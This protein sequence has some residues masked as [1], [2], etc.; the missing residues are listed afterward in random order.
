MLPS[1]YQASRD[2]LL[3]YLIIDEAH[4]ISH[5]GD[6]FRPDFQMLAGVRRGLLS[7]SPLNS[8]FKTIL[9]SATFT[10]DS[11]ETIDALFGPCESVHMCASVHLRP[12]PQYWVHFEDDPLEKDRKIL[13]T[14]RH[15]PRPFILYVTKVSDAKRWIGILRKTGYH[16]VDC[17]HG[18][19]PGS[20]RRRIIDQWSQNELDGI[21]A[22]SAFGVGIDKQ[23]V[24]TVIHASVPETLDR[25]Y[26]EVGRGGR[27]GCPSGSIIIYSQSDVELANHLSSPSLI[28][29]DLAFERWSTMYGKSRQ[30]DKI[31]QLI[32]I[33]LAVVPPRLRRQTEYNESWN[34]R[35]IIMMA[36]AGILDLESQS[37]AP[38]PQIE[39]ELKFDFD[40][41][42]DEYW[43]NY[44]RRTVVRIKEFDHQSPDT[45]ETLI[46]GERRRAIEL[47]TRSRLILD[48]LLGRETE[49]SELLDHLYRSNVPGRSVI[50]S[51]ACGGCPIHR[52]LGTINIH[53]SAPPAFGIERVGHFDLS[54]FVDRFPQ[55]DLNSPILLPFDEPLADSVLMALL[56]DFIGLFGVHEI[57]IQ[58]AFRDRNSDFIGV[59][60]HSIDG[61]VLIQ[62]LE[63]EVLRPSSYEL[64]RVSLW[65]GSQTA[66]LPIHLFTMKRPLH[67]IIA[68]SSAQDPWN[69]SRRFGETGSNVLTIDQFRLGIRQ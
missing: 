26:Q 49:V 10:S 40:A 63:E 38:V 23:D 16:R 51:K 4:L 1:L 7:V 48:Q 15:A 41:R 52:Q 46:A 69:S 19:S 30:L 39:D 34:M 57:G 18:D 11:V 6:G 9:M 35:T 45:F 67:V 13:E 17:F 43:S 25:F 55:L 24:R 33:D 20:D 60:R 58:T 29:H 56:R 64:P 54:M 22:T 37:P 66:G 28:S 27:D 44:Y 2:G 3:A 50:V 31:G 65:M 5:W 12:E 42:R 32:E 53:Y 47:V 61:L 68:P 59:H 36:R 14:L 8:R 21:V 62:S